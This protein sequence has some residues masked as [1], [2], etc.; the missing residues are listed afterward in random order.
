[1]MGEANYIEYE[2][3]PVAPGKKDNGFSPIEDMANF[4]ERQTDKTDKKWEDMKTSVNSA[5]QDFKDRVL[6]E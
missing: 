3:R 5:K 4:A 2:H 1:M 6:S